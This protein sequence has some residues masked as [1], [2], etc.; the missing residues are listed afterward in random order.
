MSKLKT[1]F[2]PLAVLIFLTA[3][4]S[5]PEKKNA[6]T[7]EN[8]SE[9]VKETVAISAGQ[10][11]LQTN[12]QSCHSVRARLIGPPLEALSSKW[13]DRKNLYAYVHNPADYISK[14]NDARI[15]QLHKEYTIT[16]P[17]FPYL[18]EAEIDSILNYI[19]G[20]EKK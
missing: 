1:G 8:V 16:M 13:K 19:S 4:Q 14:K 12:C 9:P 18:K 2:L 17:P 10:K 11:L 3:C 20:E 6:D 15:I 7:G 5:A